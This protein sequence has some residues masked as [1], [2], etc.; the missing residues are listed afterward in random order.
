LVTL[1]KIQQNYGGGL[2][3]SAGGAIIS[4]NKICF[5]TGNNV[6]LDATHIIFSTNMIYSATGAG[7]IEAGNEGS[8]SSNNIFKNG[9]NGLI[10]SGYWSM[11]QGNDIYQNGKAQVFVNGTNCA[12]NSNTISSGLDS[13]LYIDGAT[14][15]VVTGNFFYSNGNAGTAQ[16]LI[17]AWNCTVT[18]NTFNGNNVSGYGLKISWGNGNQV[19]ENNFYNHVAKDWAFQNAIS[20]YADTL[21]GFRNNMGINTNQAPNTC[22]FQVGPSRYIFAL[23]QD[24]L[25]GVGNSTATWKSGE[26]Y[27]VNAVDV[28]IYLSNCGGQTTVFI[29]GHNI[30]PNES[31]ESLTLHAPIG[32][33]VKIVNPSSMPTIV[34]IPVSQ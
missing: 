5:N 27:Y 6:Y 11:I 13:G 9:G 33:A 2:Y 14:G 7:V 22:L 31:F 34:I 28:D 32:T 24:P 20:T 15:S 18:S 10:V 16:V 30:M 1:N 12:I 26:A 3:C 8:I 4:S 23:G 19:D 29:N 21:A 17:N 25:N